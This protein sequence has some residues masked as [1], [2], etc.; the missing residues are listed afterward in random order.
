MQLLTQRV[1]IFRSFNKDQQR[2]DRFE[3]L[4][5]ILGFNERGQNFCWLLIFAFDVTY[6]L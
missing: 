6:Q 4:R 1:L 5:N 2:E 3:A